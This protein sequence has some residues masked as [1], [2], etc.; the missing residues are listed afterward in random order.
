MDS[1]LRKMEPFI[2]KKR[3]EYNED[4]INWDPNGSAFLFEYVL[5]MS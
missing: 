4:V 1:V 2:V 5:K 3:K